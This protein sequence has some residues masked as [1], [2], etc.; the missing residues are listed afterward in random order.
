M[1]ALEIIAKRGGPMCKNWRTARQLHQS[2]KAADK[3]DLP[4]Y[5][6][7]GFALAAVYEA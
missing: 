5:I 4:D 2:Y 7:N 6:S 3:H 1:T